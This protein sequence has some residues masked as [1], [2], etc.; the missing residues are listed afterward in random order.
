MSENLKLIESTGAMNLLKRRETPV[1]L[2]ILRMLCARMTL[3]D[4]QHY[5]NLEQGFAGE[6]IMDGWLEEDLSADCLVINDLLLET[7]P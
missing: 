7:E 4:D 1:E 3:P 5:L 2:M 6:R